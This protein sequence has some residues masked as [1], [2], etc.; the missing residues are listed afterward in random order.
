MT[1][2]ANINTLSELSDGLRALQARQGITIRELAER[3]N[4]SRTTVHSI[5][6]G[7]S[8]P[9]AQR[10][11]VLLRALGV[12]DEGMDAWLYALDRVRLQQASSL[13]SGTAGATAAARRDLS[14]AESELAAAQELTLPTLW[15]VTHKRLDYYHQIA[16]GQAR[17]SFRNAQ[18]A[19]TLGFILLVGFAVL[20]FNAKS[21][22]AAAVTGALGATAAAF[23]AYIGRTFVRSQET[24]ATHL[25]SYF[26]QP[27]EFSRYLAAER[28]LSSIKNL[29]SEQRAAIAADLLRGI[30][31]VP[32]NED[33]DKSESDG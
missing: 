21:T 28:L 15:S 16:T 19:M 30:L 22:A 12:S 10:L 2:P 32:K 33:A 13:P 7:L 24:A 26:D 31:P 5:L 4:F 25:R 8:V 3:A 29:D 27:L 14:E 11:L 20:A 1:D 6:R 23:A 17:R 18:V 9:S